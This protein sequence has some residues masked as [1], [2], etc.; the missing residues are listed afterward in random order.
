MKGYLNAAEIAKLLK[1]DRATVSRWIQKG[2]LKGAA[3]LE[4]THQ[5]RI[6]LTAYENFIKNRNQ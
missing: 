5:W 4:K 6:P 3:R 2:F 1:V